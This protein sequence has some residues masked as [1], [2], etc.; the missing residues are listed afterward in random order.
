MKKHSNKYLKI[1]KSITNFYTQLENEFKLSREE[2]A[3]IMLAFTIGMGA[4][5][6]WTRKEVLLLVEELFRLHELNMKEPWNETLR[7]N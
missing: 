6:I 2:A 1:S 7:S 5:K 4:G 3:D